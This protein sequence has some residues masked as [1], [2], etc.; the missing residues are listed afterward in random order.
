MVKT[1]QMNWLHTYFTKTSLPLTCLRLALSSNYFY[2]VFHSG[3][4]FGNNILD[5]YY[6]E[7]KEWILNNLYCK[8]KTLHLFLWAA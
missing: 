3:G 1:E 4:E 8:N 6:K 5:I 7:K 2:R